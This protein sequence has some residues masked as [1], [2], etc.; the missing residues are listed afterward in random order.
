MYV[1]KY[2]CAYLHTHT[3]KHTMHWSSNSALTINKGG[4]IK[5]V[6]LH[7]L[8]TQTLFEFYFYCFKCPCVVFASRRR[9]RPEEGAEP[10]GAAYRLWV[11]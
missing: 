7:G 8:A 6:H 11:T 3:H 2:M 10:F 4:E 5:G 1:N 9:Q